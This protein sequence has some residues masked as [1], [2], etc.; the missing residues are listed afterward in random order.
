MTNW[1]EYARHFIIT[2]DFDAALISTVN[3]GTSAGVVASVRNRWYSNPLSTRTNEDRV[4]CPNPR[5]AGR[6]MRVM[7]REIQVVTAY[8]EHSVRFRSEINANLMHDVCF[9]TRDGR[10]LFYL[11]RQTSISL[12]AC[13]KT[14]LSKEAVVGFKS[15]ELRL[16]HQSGPRTHAELVEVRASDKFFGQDHVQHRC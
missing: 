9:L 15:W 12:L 11:G 1:S 8:V 3:N 16:S 4:L 13:G 10:L 5:L 6:V 14:R 7:G 2:S